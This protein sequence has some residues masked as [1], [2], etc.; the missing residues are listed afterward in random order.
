MPDV[1]VTGGELRGRR[2]RVPKTGV[3][4]STGRLREAI[5][6]M[7]GTVDGA[8]VL[9]LFAGSGALGIEALSRGAAEATFVDRRTEAVSRNLTDL[10]LTARVDRSDVAAWLRRESA[11]SAGPL[12][13]LVFCDPPYTLAAGLDADLRAGLEQIVDREGKLVLETAARQPLDLE[14]PMIKE[15]EYGDTLL[16]IHSI[17][18]EDA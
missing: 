18:G 2:L 4:P 6:S 13:D 8:R 1:R 15:R 16:R 17:P 14:L 7:L 12:Y 10:G 5:F 9:D 3:R 11:S